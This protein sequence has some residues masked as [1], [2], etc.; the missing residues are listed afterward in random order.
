MNPANP[1]ESSS[2]K[3]GKLLLLCFFSSGAAAL[4]YEVLW[5]R[6]LSLLFGV[7]SYAL[8]TILIAFMAGLGLG[9]FVVGRWGSRVRQPLRLYAIAEIAIGIYAGC[10][11]LVIGAIR[12]WYIHLYRTADGPFPHQRLF[13]FALTFLVLI[14]PT[15]LMGATLPLLVL[16]A[17]RTSK[18]IVQ[19]IGKL[20]F[21]N[22]LG[23]VAGAA[24][25]GY[26]L[27]LKL[28]MT[29][30]LWTG[31][32]LNF[33][34]AAGA[35]ALEKLWRNNRPP[36]T[37]VE[38]STR[39]AS[40]QLP[41]LPI[42]AIFLSGVASM[43]YQVG[44]TRLMSLLVGGSTYAFTTILVV[45]LLGLAMGSACFGTLSERSRHPV[46]LLAAIQGA[47]SLFVWL[48]SPLLDRAHFIVFSAS[49][50]WGDHFLGFQAAELFIALMVTFIPTFFLGAT[51]P[52]AIRIYLDRKPQTSRSV[53]DLYAS[54]TL[55]TILGAAAAGFFLL[56]HPS[57]GVQKSL[58]IGGAANLTAA[59]LC[60]SVFLR[61]R[62][63]FV[64]AAWLAGL[65]LTFAAFAVLP[66]WNTL[67]V[68]SGVYDRADYLRGAVRRRN[69]AA[70][71]ANKPL[72]PF[73]LESLLQ[74]VEEDRLLLYAEGPDATVTVT[75]LPAPGEAPRKFLRING[76]CEATSAYA[77][78]LPTQVL[79]SQVGMCLHPSPRHVA[80]IGLGSGVS[81]G[82]ILSHPEVERADCIELSPSVV[83]AAKIFGQ[84]NYDA[85]DDRRLRLLLNDGRNHMMA[86]TSLYDVIISEPTNPWVSGVSNL[87]TRE[88]YL[89]CRSRLAPGGLMCQWFHSYS[90]TPDLVRTIMRTFLDVFPHATLWIYRQDVFLVGSPV[91]WDVNRA[92]VENHFR[93]S[94]VHSDMDRV[95]IHSADELLALHVLGPEE[96]RL[97]CGEAALNTDDH[98]LVE[99]QAPWSLYSRRQDEIL[100]SLRALRKPTPP[101]PAEINPQRG[102]PSGNP[103]VTHKKA[104]TTKK[105]R[106]HP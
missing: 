35:L 51:F 48:S 1:G 13:L 90:M 21:A 36:E 99:F 88:H 31:V 104:G 20:Y 92:L 15:F 2:G 4:M 74:E 39:S 54:N 3:A 23:G 34:A 80:I 101:P 49:A 78:D 95:L 61:R 22:T 73:R 12:P 41:L 47:T 86:G 96:I 56:G 29:G 71:L 87:F 102:K 64:I 43:I 16:E 59:V 55:G 66:R 81:L 67:L 18:A 93:E 65:L 83:K 8:A 26:W 70:L 38:T 62:P 32:L 52:A 69:V 50:L 63:A 94:R 19:T 76:K 42:A 79:V 60:L 6:H 89:N 24:L 5:F 11:P 75:E 72:P 45:F 28:G 40:S 77:H 68:T 53:G 84:E 103:S 44:W 17:S 14:V 100:D 25:A 7:T 9:S 82:S 10:S 85:L 57:I 30:T 97:F 33:L 58:M 91:P 37:V 106:A 105:S 98:P 27:I 46:L